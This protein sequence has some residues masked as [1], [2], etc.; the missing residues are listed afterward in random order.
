MQHLFNY[1]NKKENYHPQ[2]NNSSNIIELY[3]IDFIGLLPELKQ[4]KILF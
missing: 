4:D 1:N 2:I 3:K